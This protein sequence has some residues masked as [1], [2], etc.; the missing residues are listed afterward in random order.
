M[1]IRDQFGGAAARR[2]ALA[3]ALVVCSAAGTAQE[4]FVRTGAGVETTD[5]IDRVPSDER[6]ETIASAMLQ[7]DVGRQSQRLQMASQGD[8]LFLDYRQ[9]SFRSETRGNAYGELLA[10]LVRDRLQ[11]AIQDNFGQV[12]RDNLE[13]DTPNNR[14]NL[15]V[16]RTGP[17]F[18]QPLGDRFTLELSAYYEKDN[19]EDAAEDSTVEGVTLQ[20]DRRVSERQTW[21]LI[22][23]D[24]R[25][26]FD[27]G[28]FDDYDIREVFLNWEL[29]GART[30][31]E[32]EIGRAII[33][34]VEPALDESPLDDDGDLVRLTI[35]RE[36]GT[37]GTLA[38]SY[39]NEFATTSDAFRYEQT[40]LQPGFVPQARTGLAD[41]FRFRSAALNYAI[42]GPTLRLDIEVVAEE[43]RYTVTT[44]SDRDLSGTRLGFSGELTQRW[45][46]GTFVDLRDEDYIGLNQQFDDLIY[47]ASVNFRPADNMEL[48]ITVSHEDRDSETEAL[49]YEENVLRLQFAY[50][51][52]GSADRRIR[53]R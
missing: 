4:R 7:F 29:Q 5:N 34:P 38:L 13:A 23:T 16:A 48:S 52:V 25:I 18:I 44:Q 31:L 10:N 12:R 43:E 6:S 1:V 50:D 27:E 33:E 9:D 3:A 28:V 22:G 24:R 39:R 53:R 15:N 35:E 47:G 17:R 19:Y 42:D 26:E 37:R 32:L 21:G 51:V 11:W 45:S 49:V 8:L 30:L 40:L 2:V 41:P 20:F 46:W 14:E 36:V